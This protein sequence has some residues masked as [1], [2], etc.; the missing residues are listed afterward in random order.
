MDIDT[1]SRAAESVRSVMNNRRVIVESLRHQ[2]QRQLVSHAARLLHFRALVL[3]PDLDLRL[4]QLQLGGQ[5]LAPLLRQVLAVVELALESIQ[6]R[7]C[8]RRSRPL[9]V[10]DLFALLRLTSPRPFTKARNT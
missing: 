9:L 7:G 6:L 2:L 10:G 5:R 1:D 3:E 4:V 8:E